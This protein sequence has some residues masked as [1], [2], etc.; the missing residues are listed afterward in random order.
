VISG[1][2][3]VEVVE[4]LA[5]YDRWGGE[6]Y[7]ED[8]ISLDNGSFQAWNGRLDN[9]GQMVN[10]GVYVWLAKVRFIDGDV[11]NFAGDLTVIH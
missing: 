2:S 10:P 8:N 3:A 9:T 7:K 5:V 1:N 6:M 4:T 11:I